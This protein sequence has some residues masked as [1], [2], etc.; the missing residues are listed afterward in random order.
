M[1]VETMLQ[2][3]LKRISF[4]LLRTVYWESII[5]LKFLR[6]H[7][8]CE[9]ISSRY[10]ASGRYIFLKNKTVMFKNCGKL[11][12]TLISLEFLHPTTT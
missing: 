11:T 1:A 6:N 4:P 12:F 2:L 8:R 7:V 10:N 5:V 9:P 3:H